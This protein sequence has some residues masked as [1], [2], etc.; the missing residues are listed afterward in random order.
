MATFESDVKYDDLKTVP[1]NYKQIIYK[2]VPTNKNINK[3]IK[4][5]FFFPYT[6][7][8]GSLLKHS[9]VNLLL[10]QQST[11]KFISLLKQ[12]SEKFVLKPQ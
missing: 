9:L 11:R 12:A 7:K 3:M 8:L 6:F 10:P 2:V 1:E 5:Q 4:L